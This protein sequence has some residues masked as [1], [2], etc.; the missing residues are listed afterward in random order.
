MKSSKSDF[1]LRSFRGPG[2]RLSCIVVLA[3]TV[4]LTGC[5]HSTT[6]WATGTAALSGEAHLV[7]QGS[8]RPCRDI[9]LVPVTSTIETKIQG[10]G[11]QGTD[12]FVRDHAFTPLW[13]DDEFERLALD[14]DCASDGSFTFA[15]VPDGEYYLIARMTWS[16]HSQRRGGYVFKR[17]DVR[18]PIKNVRILMTADNA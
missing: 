11:A 7:T 5:V 9:R 8:S 2:K 10:V 16:M 14:I 12:F 15:G 6:Q 3:A 4:L 13:A 17:L 18:Q 1:T